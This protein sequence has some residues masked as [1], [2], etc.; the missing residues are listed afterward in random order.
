MFLQTLF[1]EGMS[2]IKMSRNILIILI[3]QINPLV[4]HDFQVLYFFLDHVSLEHYLIDYGEG[5]C[6]SEA[7]YD[8]L[9]ESG[10]STK[11]QVAFVTGDLLYFWIEVEIDVCYE[12]ALSGFDLE[13]FIDSFLGLHWFSGCCRIC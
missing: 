9:L 2:L 13:Q 3:L 5:S 12:V 7:S 11:E 1:N 10:G 8:F 6:D 4:F